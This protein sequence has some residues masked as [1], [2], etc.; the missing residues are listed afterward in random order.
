MRILLLTDSLGCPR[1]EIH[2]EKTW[3][4]RIIRKWADEDI[5]FYTVC[6]YGLSVSDVKMNYIRYIQPDVVIC[7]IGIVDAS[8]RVLTR[9][10]LAWLSKSQIVSKIVNKICKKHHYFFSKIRDIHYASKQEFSSFIENLAEMAVK[11]VFIIQIANPGEYLINSVYRIVED[12]EEY[13]NIIK[14]FQGKKVHLINPY[15][16][17]E[18]DDYTMGDG[19]HLNDLG[20]EL[21]YK[22]VDVVL[23]KLTHN[24]E[25]V[26]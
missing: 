20:L 23:K 3:T 13:N 18:A 8:R 19:H 24:E 12:I 16:K 4:E 9:R 21:V 26:S 6:S 1:D 15:E 22:S 14:S 17:F 7:Q 25:E 10:E 11:K 5:I 2:P